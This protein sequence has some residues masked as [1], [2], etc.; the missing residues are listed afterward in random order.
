MPPR[1]SL[2]R[3][4]QPLEM[5]DSRDGPLSAPAFL[6]APEEQDFAAWL[7]ATAG[8]DIRHYKTET[9]R[10]RLPACLR[11]A[12]AASVAE[13]RAVLEARRRCA[14]PP[15]ARWS[16]ASRTSSGTGPSSPP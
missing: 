13:A 4:L 6:L 1:A 7:F 3:R 16:S 5:T 11:A 10:R 15:W 2:L 14:A 8:L 12:R 9:L